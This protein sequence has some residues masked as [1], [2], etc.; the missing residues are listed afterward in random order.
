MKR[1]SNSTVAADAHRVIRLLSDRAPGEA[2]GGEEVPGQLVVTVSQISQRP[3]DWVRHPWQ[4]E[5][6]E[7]C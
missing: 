1:L 6:Q 3:G 5:S 2:D 4:I 7:N